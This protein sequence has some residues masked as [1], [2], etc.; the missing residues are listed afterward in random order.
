MIPPTTYPNG[1]VPAL[2]AY[3]L[4]ID[5]PN[6][7]DPALLQQLVD[8]VCE[9]DTERARLVMALSHSQSPLLPRV[10]LEL[11]SARLDRLR[12]DLETAEDMDAV[13]GLWGQR[14]AGGALLAGTGFALTGMLS[15]GLAG[16]ALGAA[17]LAAG[18]TSYGR[19]K[20]KKRA[21][22]ARRAV[23]QTERVIEQVRLTLTNT[24]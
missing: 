6:P 20:L 15:G 23:Q 17:I 18:G 24:G 16:L 13:H 4:D 12:D 5:A 9:D 21:R 1:K 8:E 14:L 22:S 7:L 10:L 19:H 3:A 11:L 2:L